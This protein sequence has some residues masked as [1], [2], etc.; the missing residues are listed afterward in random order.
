MAFI[1]ALYRLRL[2]WIEQEKKQN[3]QTESSSII[4][5]PWEKLIKTNGF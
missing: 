4:N 1:F 5:H 2:I 3:K